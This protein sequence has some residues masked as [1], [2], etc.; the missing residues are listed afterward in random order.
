MEYDGNKLIFL[1]I[2]VVDSIVK[3]LTG[4]RNFKKNQVK[5]K[6]NPGATTEDIIDC[7]KPSILKKQFFLII[8]SEQMT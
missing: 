8:H 1:A 3:N 6:S 5:I 2:I 4:S 7:I